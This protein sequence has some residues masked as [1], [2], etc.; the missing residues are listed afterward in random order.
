MTGNELITEIK[1]LGGKSQFNAQFEESAVY[2]AI[3]R[4]IDEVNKLSPVTKTIQLLNYPLR[5]ADYH[6]GIIVRKSGEDIVFDA[7]DI[8]SLAFAV[9]GTGEAI[10]SA[11]DTENIYRFTWKDSSVFTVQ[12]GIVE[13]L[14]GSNGKK[15]RLTFTGE[16]SYMIQDLSFYGE[17][18]SPIAEDITVFSP[19]V[20]YDLASEKYVGRKFLAF[21]SLPIRCDNVSLN[22]SADYKIENSSVYL[23]ADL[24]G[25][26]E[27]SFR[28]RPAAI[29][30]DNLDIEIE[31]DPEL[32]NMIAPR[33]AYY[34]YYLTDDEAADRCNIEYQRLYAQYMRIRKV[35]TPSQ[36]RDVRGW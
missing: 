35:K 27:I 19:W 10:L 32:H 3:N 24:P 28:V 13:Q 1:H 9:S 18:L 26:Y 33:A 31:V 11:S 25:I 34:L 21:D 8:K 29:D 7:S 4:A 15:I 36:F 5:P 12:R 23:R 30:S 20:K 2:T 14:I 16:Y 6:K 22:V 17:I